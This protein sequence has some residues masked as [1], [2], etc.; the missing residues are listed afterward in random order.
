[1]KSGITSGFEPVIG[2]EI[3]VRLNVKTKIFAGDLN[4]YGREPNT[5]ISEIS[6]GYP[7]TLPRLNRMAVEQAIKLGFSCGCTISPEITFDRKNYFYPDLPKG[8]QITQ[9]RNP[10]CS[11]GSIRIKSGEEIKPVA[12]TRIH[13]EED[14]GKSLH[15]QSEYESYIDF[16]R[17]GTALIEIVTEPVLNSAEEAYAVLHEVRRL[18]LY[19]D[20]SDGNM[21]EGS[22]RCDANVSVRPKGSITLGDKV[23]IKNINSVNNVRKAIA[24]EVKR[25]I[26][27]KKE[28]A[29]IRAETRSYDAISNTTTG[30][31]VKETL[32]DYRYFPDPDLTKVIV[33][34]EWLKSIQ[35][36]LPELPLD[37]EMR[38]RS[39][40]GLNDR[41]A[42]VLTGTLE[43]ANYFEKVAKSSGNHKSA[44]NWILGPVLTYLNDKHFS[45]SQMEIAPEKIGVIIQL[46]DQDKISFSVASKKLLPELIAAPESSVEMISKSLGL[47][48]GDE[49]K[50]NTIINEIVV[51]FPKEVKLYRNGTKKILEMLM[52]QVMRKSKGKADPKK[53]RDILLNALK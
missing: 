52:G 25:Q 39:E 42:S 4:R 1:M 26:H 19:L 2:L 34:D 12:L 45:I 51:D 6:L 35:T 20:I 21:Q 29:Q 41:D 8:Y 9:D 50:L 13:L 5:L 15:D 36:V 48:S 47:L 37:K 49:D 14:A 31:R 10:I 17:A 24:G 11:G 32:E 30:M 40:Y 38:F 53:A 43:I 44:A 28:N 16:N 23:E 46:I 27:L 18:I 33:S 3:H 22:L 7:G